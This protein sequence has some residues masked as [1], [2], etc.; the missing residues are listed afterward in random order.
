MSDLL[1]KEYLKNIKANKENVISYYVKQYDENTR[2]M[3]EKNYDETKFCVFTNPN[4]IIS[5]IRR[6]YSKLAVEKAINLL[7]HLGISKNLFEKKI[8]VETFLISHNSQGNYY[9]ETIFG[10][11]NVF[12]RIGQENILG[13]WSFSSNINMNLIAKSAKERNLKTSDY[14]NNIRITFLRKMGLFSDNL[15]DEEI[16]DSMEYQRQVKYFNELVDNFEK[17]LNLIA[18]SFQNDIKFYNEIFASSEICKKRALRETINEKLYSELSESDKSKVDNDNN[19]D[20]LD[21]DITKLVFNIDHLDEI[22]PIQSF[23]KYNTESLL[24]PHSKKYIRHKIFKERIEYL[25]SIGLDL[26]IIQK[27]K[28]KLF[29]SDWRLIDELKNFIPS[30]KLVNKVCE[31][32]NIA[33]DKF[34]KYYADSVIFDGD[35][36]I[37]SNVSIDLSKIDD[38]WQTVFA[39]NTKGI[40]ERIIFINPYITDDNCLDIY[41]RHELRHSLT[42]SIQTLANGLIIVKIGN[43]ISTYYNEFL[44]N[45]KLD[46]YN[47]LQ[48]QT[49]A[50]KETKEAF[51]NGIYILSKENSEFPRS[52]TSGYDRY[53]DSFSLLYSFLPESAKNSVVESDNSSLYTS[54]NLDELERCERL[55]EIN[56]LFYDDIKF[57]WQNDN[58]N[59]KRKKEVILCEEISSLN[60]FNQ[61]I[62]KNVYPL[63]VYLK[64]EQLQD[65]KSFKNS[66]FPFKDDN[67]ETFLA[68]KDLYDIIDDR[69][70]YLNPE[71]LRNKITEKSVY[72]TRFIDKNYQIKYVDYIS[73]PKEQSLET[74]RIIFRDGKRHFLKSSDYYDEYLD[75]KT[76]GEDLM[77][78]SFSLIDDLNRN[79]IN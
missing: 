49:E 30:E 53:L 34:K 23:S 48:T 12:F 64:E 50:I 58:Q 56:C 17:E 39:R 69:Y 19:Y 4:N 3:L 68:F 8:I 20:P 51:E 38:K 6:N 74:P 76:K 57:K 62:R 59:N 25:N 42:A 46:F 14:I 11:K 71:K 5:Y 32:R 27:V 43:Q 47:E 18:E 10:T 31:A 33:Y 44:L 66:L 9:L 1:N 24:N 2:E 16:I 29:F 26:K 55:I 61:E 73:K 35:Y 36:D 15:T 60:E 41:L 45:S 75:N 67:E 72:V 7:S 70:L 52:Y 78:L 65:Y 21:L 77:V 54:I 22:A 13:I 79:R 40:Y 28:D 63:V 37:N